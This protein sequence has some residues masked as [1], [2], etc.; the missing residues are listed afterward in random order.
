MT[1]KRTPLI[2]D[3]AVQHQLER[4][5]QHRPGELRYGA[6]SNVTDLRPRPRPRNH[7]S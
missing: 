2:D 1:D 3:A 7:Q 6:T 4:C 5:G